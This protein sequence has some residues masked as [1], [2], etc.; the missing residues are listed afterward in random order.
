MSKKP[1][2]IIA[3]VAISF[4][5]SATMYFLFVKK[6]GFRNNNTVSL[7]N[8]AEALKAANSGILEQ[9]KGEKVS[10]VKPIDEKEHILGKIDAP[11]KLVIYSD[12]ECPFCQKYFQETIRK[13]REEF[14]DKVVIAYRHYFISSHRNSLTAALASECASEQGKFWEM[15]DLLYQ[16][17]ANN[18]M[19]VEQYKKDVEALAMDVAKFTDCLDKEKYKDK[20]AKDI[21]EAKESGIIGT[22]STYVNGIYISGARPY[23][24]YTDQ[25]GETKEGMKSIIEKNIK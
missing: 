10:G 8:E 24:A 11:V 17:A 3:L 5:L 2:I 13:V 7:V 19:D 1:Y 23:E 12:Y 15:N 18:L 20:I 22:P 9:V 6:A 16:D 21:G 25:A 14:A 4:A